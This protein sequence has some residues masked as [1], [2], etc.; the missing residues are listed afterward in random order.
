M[1]NARNSNGLNTMIGN[2]KNSIRGTYHAMSEKHVPRYLAEFCYRFNH[3]FQQE[4]MVEWL[5]YV[6]VHTAPKPQYQ[7]KLAEV[8]R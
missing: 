2:V 1:S 3:L 6:A 7:L 8:R 4:K 5:A